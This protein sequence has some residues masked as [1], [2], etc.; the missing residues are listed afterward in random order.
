MAANDLQR[1]SKRAYGRVRLGGKRVYREVD[2]TYSSCFWMPEAGG[3]EARPA[4]F[5]PCARWPKVR[6]ARPRGDFKNHH[7]I[8]KSPSKASRQPGLEQDGATGECH[9][10]RAEPKPRTQEC[11]CKGQRHLSSVR[12]GCS[13]T[14]QPQPLLS[15]CSTYMHSA[16]L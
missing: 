16:H 2:Q 5:L 3:R 6:E 8:E 7:H 13:G 12:R 4:P 14:W 15:I 1:G 11:L 9:V 10:G